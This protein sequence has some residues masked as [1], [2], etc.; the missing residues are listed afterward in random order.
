MS[1]SYT[2]F[3]FQ[4]YVT[5]EHAKEVERIVNLKYLTAKKEDQEMWD[6]SEEIDFPQLPGEALSLSFEKDPRSERWILTVYSDESAN[7]DIAATFTHRLMK[8]GLVEGEVVFEVSY[9]S[10]KHHPESFGGATYYCGKEFTSAVG[11]GNTELAKMLT[12][13]SIGYQV[14][15]AEK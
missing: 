9:T 7:P 15:S 14:E 2:Q 3:C 12:D 1:N 8:N 4:V 6:A 13:K 10:D 11:T 5:N